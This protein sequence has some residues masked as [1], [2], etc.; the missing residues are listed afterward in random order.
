MGLFFGL[1]GANR[2]AAVENSMEKMVVFHQTLLFPFPLS[3]SVEPVFREAEKGTF[4]IEFVGAGQSRKDWRDKLTIQGFNNANDDVGMNARK[5]LGMMKE[6]MRS[7]NKEVFYCEELYSDRVAAKERVAVLM[8]L[9]ALPGQEKRGQYG[10]YML[11]EGDHDLYI[12]QRSWKGE[13]GKKEPLVMPRDELEAWL[14]DFKKIVLL[15][16]AS[17]PEG[18]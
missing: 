2:R 6:E 14:E 1:F 5:L 7:L 17:P 11:L 16:R 9:R 12:V 15:D 8:G 3:W 18:S 4:V 13:G 10:L